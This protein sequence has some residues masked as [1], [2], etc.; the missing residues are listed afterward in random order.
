MDDIGDWALT[1]NFS[2]GYNESLPKAL[3]AVYVPVNLLILVTN[4]FVIVTFIKTWQHGKLEVQ[5]VFLLGLVGSDLTTFVVFTVGAVMLASGDLPLAMEHCDALGV[6]S[7]AMVSI[8]VLIHCSMCLDRIMRVVKPIKH[9]IWKKSSRIRLV[10]GLVVLCCYVIPIMVSLI[11]RY[12]FNVD[13]SQ[14]HFESDIPDCWKRD[15]SN[16]YNYGW[17]MATC[18]IFALIVQVITAVIVIRAIMKLKG[19]NRKRLVKATRTVAVTVGCFYLCWIPSIVWL[20][21]RVDDNLDDPPRGFTFFCAM[22]I[23]L[24]SGLSFIIYY[25]MLPKF[26]ETFKSLFGSTTSLISKD[27]DSDD[28]DAAV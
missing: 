14:F 18:L 23:A 10:A 21:W 20:A 11:C 2:S 3:L 27:D 1:D 26:N 6:A 4:V 28:A 24:N 15:T 13:I 7:T 9:M 16:N 25:N 8:T 5:H 17:V 19:T 12:A 22:M